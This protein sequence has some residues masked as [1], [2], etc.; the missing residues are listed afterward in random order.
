[1]LLLVLGSYNFKDES[2]FILSLLK[3][4]CGF[5]FDLFDFRDDIDRDGGY[6]HRSVVIGM[7]CSSARLDCWS[8]DDTSICWNHTCCDEFNSWLLSSSNSVPREIGLIW[9]LLGCYLERRAR[10]FAQFWSMKVCLGLVSHRQS[11]QQTA[12]GWFSW[13]FLVR[14]NFVWPCD[15]TSTNAPDRHVAKENFLVMFLWWLWIVLSWIR[16][17]QKSNCY[18]REGHQAVCSSYGDSTSIKGTLGG[19]M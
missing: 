8:C 6:N 2:Q 10:R 12:L 18:H 16:A 1:M 17:I 4:V 11:Q 7:E 14:W 5:V 13:T 15:H 3:F 19:V 9:K